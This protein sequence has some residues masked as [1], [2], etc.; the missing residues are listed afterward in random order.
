[1][2]YT[3]SQ[4]EL[5]FRWYKAAKSHKG[6]KRVTEAYGYLNAL[7]PEKAEEIIKILE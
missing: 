3:K 7:Q 2:N 4:L 1:V 5:V 6:D